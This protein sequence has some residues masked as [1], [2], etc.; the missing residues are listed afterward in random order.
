MRKVMSLAGTLLLC[1]LGSSAY[2]VTLSVKADNL[3]GWQTSATGTAG[4]AFV[5]GPGAPP[6]GT[7]SYSFSVGADGASTA[8][9]SMPD[10]GGADLKFILG[11]SYSTNVAAQGAAGQAPFLRLDIDQDDNGS[12]DDTL[13]FVPPAGSVSLDAWQTWDARAGTWQSGDVGAG[14]LDAYLLAFPKAVIAGDGF[15]ISVGSA[16]GGWAGFVGAIDRVS[17]TSDC[18]TFNYDFEGE[19][20]GPTPIPTP[21]AI[22][23]GLALMGGIGAARRLK[24]PR[25]AR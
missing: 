2:G 17:I 14:S 7:G 4:G 5:A 6:A 3:Q 1:S 13:T 20:P 10:F 25:D 12:I 24:R 21:A 19:A 15:N 22:W 11:L 8:T 23:G 9:L 16:S 18:I